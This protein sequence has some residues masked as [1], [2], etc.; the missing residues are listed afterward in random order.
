MKKGLRTYFT[1]GV[2]LTEG[3]TKPGYSRTAESLQTS[4]TITIHV[5]NYAQVSPET[6]MEAEKIAARV[7]RKAGEE[8]R[9][10]DERPNSQKQK[11]DS[12]GRELLYSSDIT[13]CILPRLMT[14]SFGLEHERLGFAPGQGADRRQ[15]YVFYDRA[16][17]L[18][19]QQRATQLE[20]EVVGIHRPAPSSAEI[21]GH[22]IAHE[23]GHLLGLE[24]HSQ[25]GIMR[26]DWNRSDL[27]DAVFGRLLFT[28]QQAEIIRAEV[29]RRLA[30][31]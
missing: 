27:Q 20:E 26:A 13:L 28:R 4:V 3:L 6:L 23:L 1:L 5:Y 17:Q 18:A 7:F 10:R 15:A 12:V 8:I 11:E 2:I 22:A 24:S 9:L 21:L 31:R 19:R 14:E 25:T 29:S 30:E 16:E